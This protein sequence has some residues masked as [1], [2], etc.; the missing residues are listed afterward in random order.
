MNFNYFF[1]FGGGGGGGGGGRKMNILLGMK[2]LCMFF[3]WGGGDHIIGLYLGVV[4]MHF[5][6][7]FYGQGTGLGIFLG[8]LKFRIFLG[9][10]EIPDIYF[11]MN[12]RCSARAYV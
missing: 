5:R 3:F 1:F 12:G 10:L 9:V 11:G 2:I 8:W 7:L 6:V 4:S